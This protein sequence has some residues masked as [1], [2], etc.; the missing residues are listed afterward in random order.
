[1][2]LHTVWPRK[3]LKK[4]GEVKT[5]GFNIELIIEMSREDIRKN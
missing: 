2:D 5:A 4:K 3:K 1:M